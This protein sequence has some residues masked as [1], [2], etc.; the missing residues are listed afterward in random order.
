MYFPMWEIS[1]ALVRTSSEGR[2]IRANFSL[3]TDSLPAHHPCTHPCHAPSACPE[4]DPCQSIITLTCPCGRIRQAVHCGRSASNPLGRETSLQPKCSNECNI[5]KRNARLADALGINVE[6]REKA[7]VSYNDELTAFARTNPKFLGLV[8]KAFA[9][10]ALLAA[11]FN[12]VLTYLS[13]ADLS[14]RRKRHRCYRTC[15]RIAGISFI[16]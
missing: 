14:R 5:A 7:S 11:V 8:E 1:Q 12:S 4:V 15:P 13:C 10:Y 2:T 3:P 6:A 9:E 16:M